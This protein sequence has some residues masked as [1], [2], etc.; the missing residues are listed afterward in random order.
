[1][2]L[3]DVAEFYAN[4]LGTK[5]EEYVGGGI[6]G[7]AFLT[8]DD[9]VIKITTSKEEAST[10]YNLIGKKIPH[11]ADY[12]YVHKIKNGKRELYGILM[13]S[14]FHDDD[15]SY[16]FYEMKNVLNMLEADDVEDIDL[17]DLDKLIESG[18]DID[19]EVIAFIEEYK[20][21]KRVI[22]NN[23]INNTD[24]SPYNMGYKKNGQLA[25]FDMMDPRFEFDNIPEYH[26][27]EIRNIIRECLRESYKEDVKYVNIAKKVYKKIK[28][29]INN[30]EFHNFEYL[31][32]TPSGKVALYGV[33]FNLR[34]LIPKFDIEIGFLPS[35]RKGPIAFYDNNNN[36]LIFRILESGRYLSWD[37]EGDIIKRERTSEDIEDE[38]RIVRIR[39]GSWVEEELFVHEFIHYL[40]FIRFSDTYKFKYPQD[41]VEYYNSPEE[42]NAF[43]QEGLNNI[44]RNIKKHKNHK[45][46][47]GFFNHIMSDSLKGGEPFDGSFIKALNDRNKK[48]LIKRLQGVYETRIE[49]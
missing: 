6:F 42:F 12:Y 2:S 20:E 38:K 24:Y 45:N 36:I 10:A 18:I 4:K 9:K 48:R 26:I 31:A 49:K 29:E 40:D 44:L 39:F 32:N 21:I 11:I 13:E 5:I 33:H 25:I 1:M 46:F 28:K 27:S 7:E 35:S 3:K 34:E 19:D 43:Y 22:R 47:K 16:L 37:D 14:L 41:R 15:L 23:G 17:D 30:I 8:L